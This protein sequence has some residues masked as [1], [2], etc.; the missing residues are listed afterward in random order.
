M[1]EDPSAEK[2]ESVVEKMQSR[3]KRAKKRRRAALKKR[4]MTTKAQLVG[5]E[6]M[7]EAVEAAE[8]PTKRITRSASKPKVSG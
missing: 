2:L 4:R 6:N 3:S 1:A 5:G 8:T 7:V